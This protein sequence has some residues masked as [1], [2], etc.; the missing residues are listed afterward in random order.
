MPQ[1]LLAHGLC[2]R[3]SWS[4]GHQDALRGVDLEVPTGTVL[5]LIGRNGAGKTTFLRIASTSLLPTAGSMQVLGHDVVTDA[6]NVRERIAVIPQESRPFYWMNP[7]EL[8]YYYL[9]MRG[10]T[11]RVAREK[12]AEALAELGL[13]RWENTVVSRLSGGLRRRAMVAMVMASDAEL[14]F[15]DEP[16]TGLDPIARRSVW[17]AIRKAAKANRTIFL[18]THYLDEADA[19]SD[20]LA[21]LESGKLLASGTRDDLAALARRPYRVEVSDGFPEEELRSYGDLSRVGER[22]M[23]FTGEKEA[24][25]LSRRAL[26]KGIRLSLGPVSLEDIFLQMVGQDISVEGEE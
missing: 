20:R 21:L 7:R 23:L 11:H 2:R 4:G 26:E 3:Y 15:L 5:G 18:T 6:V 9:T 12:A 10:E 25:E 22:W 8:V 13:T 16:T 19:L 1:A 24:R 14:L 17:E